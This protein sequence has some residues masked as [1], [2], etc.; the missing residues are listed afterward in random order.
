MLKESIVLDAPSLPQRLL[1]DQRTGHVAH[2]APIESPVPHAA[3]RWQRHR[4]QRGGVRRGCSLGQYAAVWRVY[5]GV[6][7]LVMLLV[8]EGASG[9]GWLVARDFRVHICM[10]KFLH[11]HALCCDTHDTSQQSA[12]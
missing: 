5:V 6:N 9:T 8:H 3:A 12:Q 4:D 11:V 7:A 1:P 10:R 2:S